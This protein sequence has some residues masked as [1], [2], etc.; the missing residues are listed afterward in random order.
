MLTPNKVLP[1]RGVWLTRPLGITGG[2][3]LRTPFGPDLSFV[4]E[5]LASGHLDPQIGWRGYWE[6]IAVGAESLLNRKITAR[7]CST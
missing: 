7:L 4:V 1:R 3:P 6:R 5:L 2:P